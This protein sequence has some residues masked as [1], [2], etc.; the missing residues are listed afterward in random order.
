MLNFINSDVFGFLNKGNAIQARILNLLNSKA[1][2]VVLN[3]PLKSS[4]DTMVRV[5]KEPTVLKIVQAI[6]NREILLV[7]IPLENNIPDSIPFVKER[8]DGKDR[9][10]VN[11]SKYVVST[12]IDDNTEYKID[13]LK[14]YALVFPAYVYLKLVS[15]TSVL[16]PDAMKFSAF[17]WARMFCKVLNKVIGLSTNKDRYNAFMYMA[18]RFYLKYYMEAPDGIVDSISQSYIGKE[19]PYILTFMESQIESKGL[20]PYEN[21]TEFCKVLFNNEVTNLRGMRIDGIGDKINLSYFIKQ[22]TTMYSMTALMS[23]SSFPFF[24]FT[25]FSAYKWAGFVND[26]ALEDVISYDKKE[27][28]KLLG[29]LYKDL[30]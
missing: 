12:T 25:I 8:K 17:I 20:N 13:P 16:S 27:M 23:L 10:I 26:R 22:Y 3:S 15:P 4:I 30:T 24:L 19:K 18:I 21:L 28:E 11:V 2:A 9:V 5:F 1:G 14:L 6:N 29:S 7:D